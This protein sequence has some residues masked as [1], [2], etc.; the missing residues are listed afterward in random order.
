MKV[1]YNLITCDVNMEYV[2]NNTVESPV[3][4]GCT[5]SDCARGL[6]STTIGATTA[7]VILAAILSI[8]VVLI[9]VVVVIRRRSKKRQKLK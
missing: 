5:G 7:A 3:S 4:G 8:A 9:G 1:V 2:N 6:S